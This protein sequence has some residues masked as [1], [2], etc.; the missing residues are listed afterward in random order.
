ML[1]KTLFETLNKYK[2][3]LNVLSII[4]QFKYLNSKMV[5]LATIK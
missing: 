1:R 5:C 3:K 2:K 4:I